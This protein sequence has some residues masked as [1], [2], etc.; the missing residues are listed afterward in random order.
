VWPGDPPFALSW[1]ARIDRGD[2]FN[3]SELSLS[4]HTGAHADA[5]LHVLEAGADVASLPLEAYW[6]PVRV[7]DWVGR[8][9]IDRPALE[10]EPWERVERVLFRTRGPWGL[11]EDSYLTAEAADF[12]CSLGLR[13]VGIDRVSLDAPDRAELPVHRAFA[14][15]GVATLECLD[16]MHVD[17]GEYDL[18]ALP[19]ALEGADASPVRAAL[20]RR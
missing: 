9:R 8:G 18:V 6:G 7:I 17:A 19:L 5:P 15:S 11:E 4:P 16:L 14:R 12:L 20:R 10:P 13:L 3:L 2:P 1:R